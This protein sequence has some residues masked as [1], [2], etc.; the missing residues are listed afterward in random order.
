MIQ[1][2]VK[3]IVIVCRSSSWKCISHRCTNNVLET[4]PAGLKIDSQQNTYFCLM[5]VGV[6]VLDYHLCSSPTVKLDSDQNQYNK[7]KVWW[8][9]FCNHETWVSHK[10]RPLSPLFLDVFFIHREES[11]IPLVS[12]KCVIIPMNTEQ[13]YYKKNIT[14][15][16]TSD[17]TWS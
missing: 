17:Q 10:A 4:I 12:P 14:Y 11:D 1:M 15:E 3:S 13:E 8:K 2:V 9:T 6:W 5:V 16:Q 7:N